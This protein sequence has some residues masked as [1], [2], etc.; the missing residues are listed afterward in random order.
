MNTGL[1]AFGICR[2]LE[3]C[4]Q[5]FACQWRSIENEK[6]TVEQRKFNEVWMHSEATNAKIQVITHSKVLQLHTELSAYI[7]GNQSSEFFPRFLFVFLFNL[8]HKKL[9]DA[10]YQ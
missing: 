4:L 7:V 3:H 6:E 8:Y 10:T 5:S 1:E 9:L 2:V